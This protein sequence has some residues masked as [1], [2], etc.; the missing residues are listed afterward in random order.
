[1]S[2]SIAAHNA[3]Q[4]IR[5]LKR[6]I[7]VGYLLLGTR[8]SSIKNDSLYEA[9]G[10]GT[11]EEFIK[12]P[13]INFRRSTAYNLIAISDRFYDIIMSNKLDI[14]YTKVLRL[15]PLPQEDAERILIDS[16]HLTGEDFNNSIREVR[17]QAT[18]D[19]CDHLS[20]VSW[21]RCDSCGK[22]I[23]I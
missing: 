6:N 18:T 22:W 11:F 23:K 2:R 14:G 16:P 3:I 10:Y 13:D 19:L 1:M 17:G 5:D 4:E 21:Q 12:D 15:L 20:V 9:W 8:L 7:T